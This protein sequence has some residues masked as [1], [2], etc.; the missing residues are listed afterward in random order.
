MVD[1][2]D[3]GRPETSYIDGYGPDGFRIGGVLH[4]GPTLVSVGLIAAWPVGGLAEATPA[5]L[6]AV[7]DVEPAIELLILGCGSRLAPPP[8]VLS[9]ALRD[10][11]IGL[12]PM[13]SGAAC[14]TYNLLL[15]E[16]RSI[17][18]ALL[19]VGG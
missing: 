6:A 9:V 14:R 13:D 5:S 17:A 12:E 8:R 10:R 2:S 16:G 11:G 18:A 19:P 15:V 4:P 1:L 7:L 3:E